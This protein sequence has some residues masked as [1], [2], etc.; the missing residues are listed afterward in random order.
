VIRI[1][2][3][4]L[5]TISLAH[6]QIGEVRVVKNASDGQIMRNG[7]KLNLSEG[8]NLEIGDNIQTQN[9]YVAILLYPKI[10][11]SLAKGTDITLTQHLLDENTEE[12]TSLIDLVKG[13]IRIQV[14]RDGGERIDQKVNAKGVTFAVRGTEYEVS[15][16]DEDVELDVFDG[17]VEVTSPFVKT[18]VPEIVKPNQGFRFKRK[19]RQFSRRPFRERLTESG[20]LRRDDI[21]NRWEKR[22]A[23]RLIKKLEHQ[24][25][26]GLKEKKLENVKDRV[27]KMLKRREE[28]EE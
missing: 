3:L 11:M 20:F 2:I 9:S 14:T 5:I 16:T 15:S 4:F 27:E 13:L 8:M 25:N 1:F 22:K 10:Q 7:S 18:L 12:T 28:S 6:A 19:E 17:E 21:R 26:N 23:E 24:R